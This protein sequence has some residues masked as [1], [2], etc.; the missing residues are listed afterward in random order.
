MLLPPGPSMA[1]KRKLCPPGRTVRN[2]TGEA[3]PTATTKGA[4]NGP[5]GRVDSHGAMFGGRGASLF[6]CLRTC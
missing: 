3:L 5:Q 2:P 6:T 4:L 1:K